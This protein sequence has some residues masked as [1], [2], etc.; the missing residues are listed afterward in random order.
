MN[1]NKEKTEPKQF[2]A[3][4]EQFCYNYVINPDTKYNATESAIKA[5]YSEDTAYSIASE[6]LR[7]PEIK[8]KINELSREVRLS[9]EALVNKWIEAVYEIAEDPSSTK[10][11]RLRAYDMIGKYLGIYVEKRELE[12]KG[13]NLKIEFIKNENK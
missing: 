9:H 3:K 4:Q 2:T 5:G 11:I 1:Q 12:H 6:L 10:T 7:K 13:L 8:D